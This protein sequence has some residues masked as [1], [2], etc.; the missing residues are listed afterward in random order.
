MRKYMIFSAKPAGRRSRRFFCAADWLQLVKRDA[1]YPSIGK[2]GIQVIPKHLDAGQRSLST[3]PHSF[4][5]RNLQNIVD[6]AGAG[7][8]LAVGADRS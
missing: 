1:D 4:I 3:F 6:L 5:K 8:A 2:M 7:V